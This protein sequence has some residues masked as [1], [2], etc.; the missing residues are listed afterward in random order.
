MSNDYVPRP[1]N[2]VG[3]IL[4]TAPWNKHFHL[5]YRWNN[6]SSNK[7]KCGH[8]ADTGW[9]WDLSPTVLFHSPFCWASSNLK[10]SSF[11]NLLEVPLFSFLFLSLSASHHLFL[12]TTECDL[13]TLFQILSP[14][15]FLSLCLPPPQWLTWSL[16]RNWSTFKTLVLI[17]KCIFLFKH[18]LSGQLHSS[19]GV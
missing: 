4:T 12:F 2:M 8:R 9:E 1:S 14:V 18:L 17:I 15:S 13:P 6:C 5:F 19:V 11:Q 10:T 16:S 7:K 3:A